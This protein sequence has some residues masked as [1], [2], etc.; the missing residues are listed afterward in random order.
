MRPDPALAAALK[1]FRHRNGIT[2]RALASKAS[3]T[4]TTISRVERGANSPT[5]STLSAIAR[6]LDVSMEELG[7][8]V[9]YGQD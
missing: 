9:E 2:Q 5:W 6:A 4:V 8:A 1:R 3:V 7:S